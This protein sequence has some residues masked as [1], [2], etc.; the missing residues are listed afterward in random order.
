ML[1]QQQTSADASL[2]PADMARRTPQKKMAQN[3]V[4]DRRFGDLTEFMSM[5]LTHQ[6]CSEGNPCRW[7]IWHVRC[8]ASKQSRQKCSLKEFVRSEHFRQGSCC[9]RTVSRFGSPSDRTRP[10]EQ[11]FNVR[12]VAAHELAV[13][14][15]T[16]AV[17]QTPVHTTRRVRVQQT[18]LDLTIRPVLI[19]GCQK[20]KLQCKAKCSGVV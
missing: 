5:W 3:T 9:Q 11:N 19:R 6:S 1:V 20:R 7:Q 12:S 13:L 16:F 17:P 2:D 14:G 15:A 18:C 4:L 10:S 8:W